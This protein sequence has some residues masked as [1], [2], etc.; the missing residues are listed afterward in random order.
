[1]ERKGLIFMAVI[2]CGVIVV[3]PIASASLAIM[4]KEIYVP[5]TFYSP[6]KTIYEPQIIYDPLEIIEIQEPIYAP[7]FKVNRDLFEDQ[8]TYSDVEEINWVDLDALEV[9]RQNIKDRTWEERD[10]HDDFD[11]PSSAFDPYS[12]E[13]VYDIDWFDDTEWDWGETD[14]DD[15]FDVPDFSTPDFNPPDFSTPDFNPP[16]FSTPDINPPSYTSPSHV[17]PATG[18]YDLPSHPSYNPHINP[19]TGGYLP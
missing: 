10:F 19:S 13:W 1:M 12:N 2:L 18:G 5:K 4:Q 6:P 17:N 7:P 9:D 8:K 11:L 16:D 3:T 14:F 15:N